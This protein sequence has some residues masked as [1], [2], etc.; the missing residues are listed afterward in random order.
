M[1]ISQQT[2]MRRN[3]SLALGS[4]F[5]PLM[6][7]LEITLCGIHLWEESFRTVHLFGASAAFC[8]ARRFSC[9]W[10]GLLMFAWQHMQGRQTM[11]LWLFGFVSNHYIIKTDAQWK[12]KKQKLGSKRSGADCSQ[13]SSA[14][15]TGSLALLQ[16]C[17]TFC[18]QG[19]YLNC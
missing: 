4:S 8:L 15:V 17:E 5:D 18:F 2:V 1:P 3:G 9:I 16:M 11:F 19:K 6:W 14:C 13:Q 7:T 12:L 10:K